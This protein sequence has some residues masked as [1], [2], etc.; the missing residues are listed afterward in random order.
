MCCARVGVCNCVP[1]LSDS[2]PSPPD[3]HPILYH[4][5]SVCACLVTR[6]SNATPHADAMLSTAQRCARIAGPRPLAL[7]RVGRVASVQVRA[8]D[9]NK[10]DGFKPTVAAF[11]P[12]QGAQTVGMAKDLVAEVPAAKELFDKASEILG[13]DLLQVGR[14]GCRRRGEGWDVA[15]DGAGSDHNA[16]RT[17]PSTDA[18]MPDACGQHCALWKSQPLLGNASLM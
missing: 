12:G 11:F 14:D 6:A 18:A 15:G 5:P 16:R 9:D 8:G 4:G 3:G 7:R 1:R 2:G 10:F 13:Y 17:E